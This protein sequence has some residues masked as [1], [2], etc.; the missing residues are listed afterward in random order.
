[1]AE[2]RARID[3]KAL[4]IANSRIRQAVNG[5]VLIQISGKDRNKLADDFADRMDEV[6]KGK[7]IRID[8]P[9]KC[10]ELRV[11]GVDISAIPYDIATAI[12]NLGKCN[13]DEVRLGRIRKATRGLGT[14]WVRCPAFAAK[15]VVSVGSVRVGWGLANID[16]LRPR[17]LVCFRCFMRGHTRSRCRSKVDRSD[18]CY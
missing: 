18:R 14:V 15:R 3:L 12:A 7:G 2:A 8:R 6:L 16:L 4:G 11:R 9:S 13:K 17:P 1:M 5:E 10:A